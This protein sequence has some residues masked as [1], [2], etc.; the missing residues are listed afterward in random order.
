MRILVT[1]GSGVVGSKFVTELAKGGNEVLYTYLSRD[2]PVDGGA[3][4]RLDVADGGSVSDVVA[5]FEPDV[6]LHLAALTNADLC[7]TNPALA[8][9]VNVNGTKN[10]VDA[11]KRAGSKVIFMSSAFVFDGSKKGF[12]E[13]DV[14][15]PVNR[16]GMSKLMAER[17]VEG[18]GQPFMILRTDL[19]YRWSP[20]HLEKN[21][22]MK[23]IR[24]FESGER[25]REVTDWFNTPTL[26]DDLVKV[27]IALMDSWEDGTYHVAG[28]DF[29]SRYDFAL[30]VAGAMGKDPSSIQKIRSADLNLPAKRP[31]VFLRSAKAEEKTGIRMTGLDDGIKE[32]LRQAS[33]ENRG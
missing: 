10:V 6:V 29:V 16:Y 9:A 28:P 8:D 27:S 11:C 30:K 19:P 12:S 22:I 32:V 20:R 7:E 26:V 3:S 15:N 1:G 23:L 4:K 18:S 21:N 31:N 14:P 5:G 2:S 17:C 25:Y 24:A 13:E 33:L